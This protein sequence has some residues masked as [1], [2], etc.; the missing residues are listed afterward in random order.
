MPLSTGGDAGA[1]AAGQV[2]LGATASSRRCSTATS[3]SPCTRPR[4]C[5]ASSP[6]D[7]RCSALPPAQVP[8]TCS[9]A[10]RDWRR[11]R[12]ARGSGR[13]ACAGSRSCAAP[14]PTS[15]WCRC[16]ATS[17]RA[18]EARQAAE[19]LDAIVLA[20]AGLQRLGREAEAGGLLD[21]ARFVPAP[22]P[23]SARAARDARTTRA[24]GRRPQRITDTAALACLLAER[25][26]ARALGADCH[27]PLGAHA[28][29][30]RRGPAA[31]RLGRAARRLGVG[32]R[33]AGRRSGSDPRRSAGWW[34]SGCGRSGRRSCWQARARS[35][36]RA[37]PAEEGG[38]GRV[39][40]VGAG[41]GDPGLLSARALE[42]I[43]AAD[44]IL[45]DR[46]VAP[47]RSTAPAPTPSSLFVGKE[48]G[49]PQVPQAETEALLL[50][51]ARAGS[52]VVRLKGGDPF[53][54]GRGGEEALTLRA[55]RGPLRD[56]AGH[57]GGARRARLCGHPRHAS[58]ALDGG[59]AR[60]GAHSRRGGRGRGARSTGR[61]SPRSPGRSSSTW[62]YRRCRRSP[63]G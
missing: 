33:R 48:G 39:Y 6:P 4:T 15:R 44:V 11:S 37:M 34:Q 53:V 38:P 55:G 16:E 59:R 40:L 27:T 7:S 58:R 41:P 21:P 9:A 24:P 42:L 18:C 54:F 46:L 36:R 51:H 49:G 52:T 29:T 28:Q 63:R 2:A 3:T 45:Y 20:R 19:R 14:A 13:A 35:R 5:P 43:A 23:G 17:T 8:R 22:G 50:E 1:G 56:R 31:A 60:H 25:A 10:P 57:D 30:A 26:L 62:A 61:R 47:V 12:P 32:A